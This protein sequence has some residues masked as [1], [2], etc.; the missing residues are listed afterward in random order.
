MNIVIVPFHDYKKW[1]KEGFRT[2]DAH[3]CQHF[4][5]DHNVEKIL[6]INRPVSIAEMILKRSGWKTTTGKVVYC[7]NGVQISQM[8]EKVWCLDILLLDF[9]KVAVQKKKWWFTAFKY[10]KVLGSINMAIECLN[11][12]DNILMLQN[13]MAIG[14]A[15][16]VRRRAFVFD[17]IDNWIYHPQMKDKELIKNNYRYVED[18]AD[19]ILT[20]SKGLTEVFDRNKNVHWVPNGVD[21]DFFESAIKSTM[22]NNQ[23]TV[24]G[25]VGK[26]Q[27]RVDFNL[28][29]KCLN[30]FP[31][32]HFE[33]LGPIY[34]QHERIKIIE[35]KYDNIHFSGD[36][37]YARLPSA[38][39]NF[40]VAII[41]HKI[42]A[43][44]DSMNPLK[45]YEYLAAGKLVVTT[46]VAGTD[47]ISPYVYTASNE[48][49]F[50][51][52]LHQAIDKVDG[53]NID[54]FEI[55][56]SIPEECTWS[57]R[58]RVILDLFN[59]L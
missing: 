25:Y 9:I 13:P 28:V 15:E 53:Q 49:K 19:L 23:K 10:P 8:S 44:T 40:D 17:A 3:L 38:M 26:I 55:V 46:G 24:V 54:Y 6:V 5:K 58:V 29:E 18:Q 16:G 27:D 35:E 41:P 51:E 59:D 39:K 48:S 14:V 56:N 21:I 1:I 42:D 2:R 30:N 33:F 20:V 36:V 31:K 43:F 32:C 47:N 12:Q 52:Y 50:L 4:E 57:N 11:I 22:N 37:H 45:L 34:T 7:K